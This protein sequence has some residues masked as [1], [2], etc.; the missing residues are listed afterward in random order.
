MEKTSSQD[1]QR[2]PLSDSAAARLVKMYLRSYQQPFDGRFQMGPKSVEVKTTLHPIGILNNEY[3]NTKFA[4][5]VST[6]SLKYLWH[7]L[8][9]MI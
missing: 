7:R 5:L 3:G 2:F 8:K 9:I 4:V 6:H 1:Q